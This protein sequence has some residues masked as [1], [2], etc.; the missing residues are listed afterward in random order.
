MNFYAIASFILTMAILIAFVNHRFIKMQTTIAM[1]SA[2]L[3][4][5]LLLIILSNF[6]FYSILKQEITH[7]L[8]RIN[9]EELLI[10]GML[11]F[12]LFAGGLEIDIKML[13]A[14]KW[15]IL[16][17]SS[18]STILSTF[19][20]AILI[21]F[22]LPLI[23]IH[24]NFIYCLLFGA[25]I[26]PTDPIAVLATFKQLNV[27]KTLNTIVAGES[28]FND[29][30]GIVMFLTLY[31]LAFIKK[32]LT[33]LSVLLLFIQQTI[34]GI[35]YGIVLG[36]ISSVLIKHADDHKIEILLT[37]A[38]ATG[39]YS[40]ALALNVSGPLAMVVTGIIIG[41]YARHYAMTDQAKGMLGEFWELID[42]ILNSVLFLLIG[43]EL[44]IVAEEN[45]YLFASVF[46]IPLVLLTRYLTVAIPISL[47]K[48]QR[49]YCPHMITFLVW[50]GLR[51]GLAVAL[52]LALPP[53]DCR[54][55]ILAMT[56]SIVMFSVVIQGTTVPPL[57]RF[58]KF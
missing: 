36:V 58:I 34:G 23:D 3:L 20:V 19:L 16:T 28:L 27:P 21:Y 8:V 52:A 22:F 29:G 51:G 7:T 56:Y 48:L 1:M 31:Q 50:G 25:L 53:S 57:V 6:G 39:G 55:L 49:R 42:E 11:S 33:V 2:S 45:S 47:F 41:S 40:L 18:F 26:S 43:L 24:L 32:E 44:L 12:L 15:E 10:N 54:Q 14:Q 35:V 30:I 17:L 5:S 46:A 9:F 38:V 37:L 4:L 13:R